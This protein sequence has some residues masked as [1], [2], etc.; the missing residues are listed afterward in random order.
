MYVYMYVR[1]GLFSVYVLVFYYLLSVLFVD[2]ILF[3]AILRAFLLCF[4]FLLVI[5]FWFLM[6]NWT[7]E[8]SGLA[9]CCR[10]CCGYRTG[11]DEVLVEGGGLVQPLPGL[12]QSTDTLTETQTVLVVVPALLHARLHTH[13]KRNV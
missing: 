10:C 11:R 8:P 6:A 7:L 12:M 5:A 4:C 3:F 1:L 13:P 2:L 9:G